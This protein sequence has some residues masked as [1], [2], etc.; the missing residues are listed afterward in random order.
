MEIDYAKLKELCTKFTP[1][2]RYDLLTPHNY[3]HFFIILVH[4]VLITRSS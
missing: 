1:T 4:V 2:E 3:C